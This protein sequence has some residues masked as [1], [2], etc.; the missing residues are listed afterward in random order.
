MD[1]FIYSLFP[2]ALDMY[3]YIYIASG[4]QTMTI[5]GKSPTFL[6]VPV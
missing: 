6:D 5:N 2:A 4:N 1:N 3:I